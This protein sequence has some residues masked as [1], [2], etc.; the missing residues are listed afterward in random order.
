MTKLLK[1]KSHF[2]QITRNNISTTFVVLV[3]SP[4]ELK[5]G[6]T[7]CFVEKSRLDGFTVLAAKILRK[8]FHS[9][10]YV[11]EVIWASRLRK[12][13]TPNSFVA[14]KTV[15]GPHPFTPGYHTGSILF[16][17]GNSFF[18]E[19]K[20]IYRTKWILI[21]LYQELQDVRNDRKKKLYGKNQNNLMQL[22]IIM[23]RILY[24][25]IIIV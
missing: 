13:I 1:S 12:G 6:D 25:I 4:K 22:V 24:Q 10:A 23:R 7:I 8:N 15:L 21:F 9:N 19:S 14:E 3:G 16:R 20:R 11:I 18:N 5:I 2:H 17:S